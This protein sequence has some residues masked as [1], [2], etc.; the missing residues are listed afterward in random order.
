[1]PAY[2]PKLNRIDTHMWKVAKTMG[3]E[4]ALQRSLPYSP[5]SRV[6]F[7][8]KDSAP[9]CSSHVKVTFLLSE[10]KKKNSNG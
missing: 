4:L 3:V 2:W 8:I 6:L 1:M 5:A 10:K 9:Y 7:M